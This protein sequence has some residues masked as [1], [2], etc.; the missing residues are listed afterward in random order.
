MT[1]KPGII[2][3]QRFFEHFINQ[4]SHENPQRL[5]GLYLSLNSDKYLDSFTRFKPREAG[6]DDILGIH[7]EFYIEQIRQHALSED[8]YSYD[9]DTY[10][11][12]MSLYTAKL[13]AGGCLELADRIM[14][15]EID[16]GFALIRPPGHH[17][18]PGRGMGFCI[19]NNVAMTA[20][21]LQNKYDLSRILIVD[22]DIHHCNGTQEAFFE[23]DKVLVLSIH[24]KEIFPFTGDSDEV[25]VFQGLGHTINIPVYPQYGDVEYTYLAGKLFQCLAEQYMPQFILVSAGYDGHVEES[26]SDTTLSTKWY[27][28][29]TAMLRNMAKKVCDNRLLFIL[30]GGYNRISL[31]ASILATLDSLVTPSIPQDSIIMSD[32]AEN[33]LKNHP[34]NQYW[35]L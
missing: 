5:R 14:A 6:M 7:S 33:I 30:E 10:L 15:Q 3:D 11:M 20:A 12:D 16:Y 23:T 9:K 17:A 13:A 4:D 24:Q 32:R 26:I 22:F 18:E 35:T 2:I 25:G 21:Y 34:I 27:G 19:L 31:E 28:D 8:P 29:V 1:K